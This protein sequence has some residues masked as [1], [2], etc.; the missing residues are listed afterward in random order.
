MNAQSEIAHTIYKFHNY[1]KIIE[2]KKT[3][4]IQIAPHTTK[5]KMNKTN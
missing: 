2:Q 1:K 5:K 4:N 3:P